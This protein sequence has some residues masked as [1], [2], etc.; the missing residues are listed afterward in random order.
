M[1]E[2]VRALTSVTLKSELKILLINDTIT[3]NHIGC[4]LATQS[5]LNYLDKINLK[6]KDRI[7]T[8]NLE[9]FYK[10]ILIKW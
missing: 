3:E 2:L 6:I 10:H 4:T 1:T 9:T 7:Y 5:Y 8:N